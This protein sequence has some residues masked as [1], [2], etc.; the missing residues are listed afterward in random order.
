MEPGV[1][2]APNVK[3]AG[4]GATNVVWPV[5]A[6]PADVPP[7]LKTVIGMGAGCCVLPP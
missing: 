1:E 7:K 5:V 4:D 6:V 3:M 2:A